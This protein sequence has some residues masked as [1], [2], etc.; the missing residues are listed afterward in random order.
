MEGVVEIVKAAVVEASGILEVL[1]EGVFPDK[2]MPEVFGPLAS[3]FDKEGDFLHGLIHDG[4]V[5]GLETMFMFLM[6]HGVS[7]DYDA[8]VSSV[9]EYTRE[10]GLQATDLARRL[11]KVLE[12]CAQSRGD[13]A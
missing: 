2:D 1:H 7:I 5:S 9:P 3:A 11:Q 8:V 13:D 6:V 4:T 12:E 10:Q